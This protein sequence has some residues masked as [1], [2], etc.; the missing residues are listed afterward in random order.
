MK[1]VCAWC[2]M[3]LVEEP[4]DD[5]C[6]SHG[7]CRTCMDRI[8]GASAKEISEFLRTLDVPV[9]V[10]NRNNQVVDLNGLAEKALGMSVAE[11]KGALAGVAI[12]CHNAGLPGGCGLSEH[13]PGCQLRRHL[14]ATHADG[15]PRLSQIS[16]HDIVCGGMSRTVRFR[17]STQK[18]GEVVVML[19]EEMN[20][21]LVAS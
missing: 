18:V 2:K 1:T 8:L 14:L 16:Q 4:A 3:T 6:V 12:S 5:T 7:I 9:M 15:Q 20:E 10:L 19:I 13:C 21:T 17:F 11:A